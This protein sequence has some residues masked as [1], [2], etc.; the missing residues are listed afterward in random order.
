V[1]IVGIAQGVNG[2]YRG[3]HAMLSDGSP[4]AQSETGD[5]VRDWAFVANVATSELLSMSGLS[6][7]PSCD[8]FIAGCKGMYQLHHGWL[9]SMAQRVCAA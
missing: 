7:A 2:E 9:V 6:L 5:P 3:V 1:I 4:L 8:M